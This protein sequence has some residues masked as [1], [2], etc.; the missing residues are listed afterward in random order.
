MKNVLTDGLGRGT[1]AYS[2]PELLTP[3]AVYSFPVDIYST[4]VTLYTLISGLEPFSKC[5]NAVH[6]LVSIQ[7][8]FF[9]SGMQTE[10]L[11]WKFLNGQKVNEE[12]VKLIKEMVAFDPWKRPDAASVI[13]QIED[14]ESILT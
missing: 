7:K 12:L 3:G 9:E 14:A 6:I 11:E 1:Q 2:A 4:G 13:V 5:R 10:R 8:G